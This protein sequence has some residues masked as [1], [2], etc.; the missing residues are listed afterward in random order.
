M[1]HTTKR[2]GQ[3][4]VD[5]KNRLETNRRMDRRTESITLRFVLTWS[6]YSLYSLVGGVAQWLERRSLAGDFPC[7]A[8]D[9]QLMDDH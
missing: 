4:L 8:L 5:S 2:Q 9:L 6:L 1:T 7:P 3:R